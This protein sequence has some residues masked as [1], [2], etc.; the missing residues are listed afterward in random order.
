MFELKFTA[1]A[2]RQM[3]ELEQSLHLKKRLNAVRKTLAY[4]E[5]NPRHPG[6]NTHEYTSLTRK[7]GQKVFEA[8][9]ENKMPGAFRIFW[10]YGPEANMITILAITPHP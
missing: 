7:L 10:C 3:E 2:D 5:T 8:Y 4:L 9:A 1:I 6:L